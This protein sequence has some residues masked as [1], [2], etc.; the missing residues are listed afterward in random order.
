MATAKNQSI[1]HCTLHWLCRLITILEPFRKPKFCVLPT[2]SS[3]PNLHPPHI[4]LLRC[5]GFFLEI[6]EQ[7]WLRSRGVNLI[8]CFWSV[9]FHWS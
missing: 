9:Q 4:R 2:S 5:G 7:R 1:R 6:K 8:F 3:L